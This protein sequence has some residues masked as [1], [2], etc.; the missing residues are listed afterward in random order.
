[1]I[2]S[3]EQN[4]H[5]YLVKHPDLLLDELRLRCLLQDCYEQDQAQ[6]KRLMKAYQENI[7]QTMLI[8]P[9]NELSF[10][11]YIAILIQNQDMIEEKAKLVVNCWTQIID[12]EVIAAYKRCQQ[13]KEL[14]KQKDLER[15]EEEKLKVLV[16]DLTKKTLDELKELYGQIKSVPLPEKVTEHYLERIVSQARRLERHSRQVPL[17][18]QEVCRGSRIYSNREIHTMLE[19]G[20]EQPFLQYLKRAPRA[21][22]NRYQEQ[23]TTEADQKSIESITREEDV[24]DYVKY[25]S[26]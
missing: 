6:V 17:K 16:K 13:E 1:M 22:V 25:I 12:S 18:N 9:Q 21:A 5:Q 15:Q 4:I 8:Q 7:V 3:I 11:K 26:S 14:K 24:F 10:Q 23:V 20:L 19:H 2:S